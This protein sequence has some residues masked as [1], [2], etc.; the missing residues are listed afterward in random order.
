M[1][2]INYFR[3]TTICICPPIV[4]LISKH[5]YLCLRGDHVWVRPN[6]LGE[7]LAMQ[8]DPQIHGL[9]GRRLRSPVYFGYMHSPYVVLVV[10][11]AACAAIFFWS[12][13]TRAIEFFAIRSSH[14]RKRQNA[15][16]LM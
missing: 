5:Y 11:S 4:N 6:G 10:W 3:S 1:I 8:P 13:R 15:A 2:A 16:T 14:T 7:R 9:C 12:N